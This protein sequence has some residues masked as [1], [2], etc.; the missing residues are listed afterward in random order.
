MR[1]ELSNKSEIKLIGLTVRTNNKNE[2]NPATSKVKPAFYEIKLHA[3]SF[4]KAREQIKLMVSTGLSSL[5]TKSYLRKWVH[6]WVKTA[7]TTWNFETI[8]HQFIATCWDKCLR[9]FAMT[10]LPG[11]TTTLSNTSEKTVQTLARAAL[12][13]CGI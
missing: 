4:R 7:S 8:I 5:R 11:S 10:L 1:K 12:V 3:R 9:L 6:W 2:M 13:S